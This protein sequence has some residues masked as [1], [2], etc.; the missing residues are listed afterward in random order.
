M[1]PFSQDIQDAEVEA[2]FM[3]NLLS[4]IQTALTSQAATGSNTLGQSMD[5]ASLVELTQAQWTW[6]CV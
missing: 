6:T 5:A 4:M 3:R 2:R 1:D